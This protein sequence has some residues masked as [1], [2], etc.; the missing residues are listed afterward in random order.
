MKNFSLENNNDVCNKYMYF[1]EVEVCSKNFSDDEVLVLLKSA[2]SGCWQSTNNTIYAEVC[3]NILSDALVIY[4]KS[5]DDQVCPK[6]S[7]A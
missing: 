7:L 3:K 4:L 2:F 5:R 6:D 1:S